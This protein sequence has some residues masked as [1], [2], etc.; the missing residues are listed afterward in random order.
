M[1]TILNVEPPFLA[2]LGVYAVTFAVVLSYICRIDT[3]DGDWR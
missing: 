1:E 3:W 2:A